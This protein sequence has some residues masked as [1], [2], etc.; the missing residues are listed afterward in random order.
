MRM[1]KERSVDPALAAK[2]HRMGS[3][4][5]RSRRAP[6][7]AGLDGVKA[8]DEEQQKEAGVPAFGIP[9]VVDVR[10]RHPAGHRRSSRPTARG[11]PGLH[12]KRLPRQL[13]PRYRAINGART[14]SVD[15]G[16]AASRGLP[17]GG[18]GAMSG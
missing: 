5:S 15:G 13:V 7:E 8:P 2:R 17:G 10:H 1:V 11:S 4:G 18:L 3:S 12:P 9:D 14:G 16:T 6:A